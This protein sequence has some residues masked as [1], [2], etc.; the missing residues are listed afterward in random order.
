MLSDSWEGLHEF[1]E[2]QSEILIAGNTDE[3]LAALELSEGELVRIAKAARERV[4]SDHTAERRALQLVSAL[5][6]SLK[7]EA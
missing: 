1:F 2:P 6:G 4:L 7:V 5:E 3:A